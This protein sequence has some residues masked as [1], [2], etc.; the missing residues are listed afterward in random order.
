MQGLHQA[1]QGILGFSRLPVLQPHLRAVGVRLLDLPE[2]TVLENW[3][4][5]EFLQPVGM[6]L[7][8]LQDGGSWGGRRRRWS[9]ARGALSICSCV[10]VALL[11]LYNVTVGFRPW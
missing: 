2:L 5:D 11:T 1:G 8:V 6:V 10:Y 7:C 4:L 3:D 9:R